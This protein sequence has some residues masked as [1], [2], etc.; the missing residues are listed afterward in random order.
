MR[1]PLLTSLA[2]AV[3]LPSAHATSMNIFAQCQLVPWA[4][5]GPAGVTT[6]VGLVAKDGGTVEWAYFDQDGDLEQQGSFPV[7]DNI[8]T[9]VA[10]EL[11]L[12]PTLAG[13]RGFM[14]F[15][16]DDNDDGEIDGDDGEDLS[17]NA[18]YV[19][20]DSSDVA[21]VPTWPVFE[22]DLDESDP[23]DWDNSPVDSLAGAAESD[24]DI[25]LQ[26]LVDGVRGSGDDTALVI[27]TTD[28][29]DSQA[30]M[31][32]AGPDEIN[33]VDVTLPNSR[34]NVVDVETIDEINNT[35][36]LRP[37]GFLRYT[38]G[39]NVDSAIGFS[40]VYSPGFGALQTLMGN[41]DI[42]P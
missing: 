6:A 11:V 19:D 30:Q 22:E 42:D 32:A 10:L 37:D 29:P 41:L 21:F 26:Y 2:L 9:G 13:I 5:F 12:D 40:I 14:L 34:V 25:Y 24:E 20:L 1:Y 39:D 27:F 36:G 17:A 4:T 15:C 8:L 35:A 31:L 16:L 28:E 3:A 7:V 18:F 38:V 23:D 33:N